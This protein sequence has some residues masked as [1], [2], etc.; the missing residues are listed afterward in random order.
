MFANIA[1]VIF[2][3]GSLATQVAAFDINCNNN[4]VLYWGTNSYFNTHGGTPQST[5]LSSF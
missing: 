2:I 5:A 1:A 4:L 3:L